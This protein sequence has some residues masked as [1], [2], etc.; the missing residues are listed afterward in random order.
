MATAVDKLT[1]QHHKYETLENRL[2]V[3]D[4]AVLHLTSRNSNKDANAHT[5][6]VPTDSYKL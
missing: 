3:I 5:T 6:Q 2:Y 4:L 1:G